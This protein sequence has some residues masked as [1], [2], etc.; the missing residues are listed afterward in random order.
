MVLDKVLM[1]PSAPSGSLLISSPS[2]KFVDLTSGTTRQTN[3]EKNSVTLNEEPR[4]NGL[5]LMETKSESKEEKK[6][7]IPARP[8]MMII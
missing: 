7:T 4:V 6:P 8:R 3:S 1:T 2:M 5:S